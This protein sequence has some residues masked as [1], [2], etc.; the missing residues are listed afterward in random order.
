[1]LVAI[2][3][4][5][6]A[7]Y[8]VFMGLKT[9]THLAAMSATSKS[10]MTVAQS[11]TMSD[12]EKA[13]AM[14]RASMAMFGATFQMI[15]KLAAAIAAAGAVL[16]VA[17]LIKWPLSDLL[18]YSVEPIPL[19]ATVFALFVYGKLRHGRRANA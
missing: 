18:A 1:M 15:G 10:S 9:L 8:E 11:T 13:A 16:Y 14:R 3:V 19:V 5:A 4:A 12:E 17:S 2:L 6:V 7:F